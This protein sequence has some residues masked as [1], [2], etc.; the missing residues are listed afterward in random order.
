[1]PRQTLPTRAVERAFKVAL[2]SAVAQVEMA[3]PGMAQ[4]PSGPGKHVYADFE[5]PD[6]SRVTVSVSVRIWPS[7]RNARGE[8][9][10]QGPTA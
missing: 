2:A 10:L 9:L 8:L 6:G 5:M 3:L 4:Q 1:M 7:D